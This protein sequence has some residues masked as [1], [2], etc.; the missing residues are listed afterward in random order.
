LNKR[1]N[2]LL[3]EFQTQ[4][5]QMAI[6]TNEFGGT[7]GIVT[8]EDIIVELVGE[9]QDEYDDEKPPVE[10]KSET[11]YVVN[12]MSSI[13]DANDLLPIALPESPITIPFQAC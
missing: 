2:D 1:I 3:R 5:I 7:A 8:M 9:I 12:A 11:E 13:S 4:H 10:K 6:V